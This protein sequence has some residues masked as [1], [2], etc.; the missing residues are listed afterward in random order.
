[1]TDQVRIVLNGKEVEPIKKTK[2]PREVDWQAIAKAK[3][4]AK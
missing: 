3:Q 4:E 1:M 2:L